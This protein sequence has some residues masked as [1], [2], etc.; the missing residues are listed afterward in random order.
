VLLYSVNFVRRMIPFFTDSRP[1]LVIVDDDPD[2][3]ALFRI[4][5][6][7]V[8]AYRCVITATDGMAALREISSFFKLS[9]ADLPLIVLTDLK[10]PK[11]SGTELAKKLRLDPK[12]PPFHVVAMS[13]S[14]RNQDADAALAAGCSAFFQKPSSFSRL[15]EMLVSLPE[16]CA[17]FA[18][19]GFINSIK[20]DAEASLA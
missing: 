13:N 20:D 7:R 12:L 9:A 8:A 1:A 18:E 19:T 16:L 4:A 5:A 3:L 2:Q 15:K 14:G 17:K 11:M 6:E 10:M